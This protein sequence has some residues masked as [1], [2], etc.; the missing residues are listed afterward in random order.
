MEKRQT[1]GPLRQVRDGG[2][3]Q[4]ERVQ[5]VPADPQEPDPGPE[6]PVRD[7]PRLHQG[8]QPQGRDGG[9][10][11]PGAAQGDPGQHEGGGGRW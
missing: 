1:V 9:E 5:A 4:R 2:Q 11:V 8:Q 7:V 6:P 3:E 10:R